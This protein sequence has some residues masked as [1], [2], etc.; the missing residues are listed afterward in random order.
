TV[1]F[2]EKHIQG[3]IGI[4][5]NGSFEYMANVIFKKAEKI[6]LISLSE[7]LSESFLRLESEGFTDV[8]Y[9]DIS[10]WFEA[11]LD[12]SLVSRVAASSAPK[13]LEK[14]VD[15]SNSEDWEV[16]HVKGVSNVPLVDIV[17]NPSKIGQDS[18]LY[19]GNGHKSMAA[20]SYLLTKNIITTDITGG[21]SAML[22]D[23]PDL[24]I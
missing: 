21:L 3:T 24:E 20:V 5:I 19:C 4:S 7:R 11:G 12:C 9:F 2:S 8:V 1:L 22:V 23:S 16:L 15:V 14:I 17:K 18:V 6:I 10:L 13:H